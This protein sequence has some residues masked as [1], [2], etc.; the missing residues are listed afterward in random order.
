M[1]KSVSSQ[2]FCRLSE[3]HASPGDLNKRGAVL[4]N[5][6][7]GCIDCVCTTQTV[8]FPL[9]SL[10]YFL[11]STAQHPPKPPQTVLPAQ[12]T[13]L[14]SA[15]TGDQWCLWYA[16]C[17]WGGTPVSHL[18]GTLMGSFPT[19]LDALSLEMSQALP[20]ISF[21]EVLMK[22]LC[23]MLLNHMP[24]FS[25]LRNGNDTFFTELPGR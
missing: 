7:L 11:F 13:R 24:Q 10:L 25:W 14:C 21:P 1:K 12:V 16:S 5:C 23:D 20:L 18:Q 6:Y 2:D 8:S 3:Q 22:A 17:L 19:C 15:H 4:Q 9:L